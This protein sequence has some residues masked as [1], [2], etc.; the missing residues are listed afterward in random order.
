MAVRVPSIPR[1]MA[2][3]FACLV[4]C[5]TGALERRREEPVRP[6]DIPEDGLRAVFR[7]PSVQ[8]LRPHRELVQLNPNRRMCSASTALIGALVPRT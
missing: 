6:P 4:K 3:V 2:S 5:L 8:Y 7:P 1:E